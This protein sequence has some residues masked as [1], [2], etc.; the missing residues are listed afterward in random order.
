MSPMCKIKSKASATAII[1][2]VV[3]SEG[4]S[5]LITSLVSSIS[6]CPKSIQ[7]RRGREGGRE[8]ER[9]REREGERERERGREGERER[10]RERERDS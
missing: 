8:R 9:E 2:L 5:I 1:R 6:P 3:L 7:R 10:E 4:G